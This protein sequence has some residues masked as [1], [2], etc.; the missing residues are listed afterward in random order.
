[1][2][3]AC[4]LL[5][6]LVLALSV[7]MTGCAPAPAAPAAPAEPAAAPAEPV[8][9]VG[10]SVDGNEVAIEKAAIKLV[11]DAK[12]GG[13]NLIT[14][15]DLKKAV[16]AKEDMII[17]DTMPADFFAKGHIPGAVNA[18]LPK[19]GVEKVTADQRAAFE[20]LLGTDKTK[21]IVVYCGF[22][23]CRRSDAGARIAKEL[24]FENVYR[25][26]GGIIAWQD[27]EYETAK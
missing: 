8:K 18:E 4:T 5:L 16:D 14:T 13:Y 26:P 23:A 17:I 6:I 22:T 7:I 9:K 3:K 12:E 15:E 1:M 19:E 27:A 20:A 2:K 10:T 24:G 25:H 21:K 11:S